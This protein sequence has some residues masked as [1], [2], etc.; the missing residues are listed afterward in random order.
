MRELPVAR[1]LLLL[2][3]LACG[4]D[5]SGTREHEGWLTELEYRFTGTAE[6][7]VLFNWGVPAGRSL[8][9]PHLHR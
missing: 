1:I 2:P 4:G 6:Q 8:S 9:G 7:G 3:C 5:S